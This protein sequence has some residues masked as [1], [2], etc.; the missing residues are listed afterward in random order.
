M[1]SG[2]HCIRSQILRRKLPYELNCTSI[3]TKPLSSRNGYLLSSSI[4]RRNTSS[5][6]RNPPPSTTQVLHCE[7][8]AHRLSL[9]RIFVW[10]ST[11]LETHPFTTKCLTS[12]VIAGLG[13]FVCQY[14]TFRRQT[15]DGDQKDKEKFQQNWDVTRTCRFSFL[16]L[17]LISPIM[18]V[19]F[20][21]LMKYIP[22]YT[23]KATVIRTS[24]DQLVC[25][26][27]FLPTW[28][29]SNM[30][31]QGYGW[32]DMRETLKADNWDMLLANWAL[33][34]P[35]QAINFGLVPSRFQV[36]FSNVIGFIWS[37]YLSFKTGPTE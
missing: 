19:W 23:V 8:G 22:G 25:A 20:G 30:A 21:A 16:G 17:A 35:A 4:I 18:H 29:C 15:N 7:N 9:Q 36:L 33:W 3:N 2:V 1:M 37:I 14:M 6:V 5:K 26:P 31:L 32:K 11:K 12:G 34:T 28:I 13:D 27:L 10:Y 24:L